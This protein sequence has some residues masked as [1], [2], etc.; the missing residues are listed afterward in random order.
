LVGSSPL[1]LL[2]DLMATWW[3]N[4]PDA[5]NGAAFEPFG[6]FAVTPI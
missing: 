1:I 3:E 2:N 5:V 6:L 4:N